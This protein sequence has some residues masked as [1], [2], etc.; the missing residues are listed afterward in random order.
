M[1]SSN[2]MWMNLN[3]K[4]CHLILK[5]RKCLFPYWAQISQ[6]WEISQAVYQLLQNTLEPSAPRRRSTKDNGLT[7]ELG[8]VYNFVKRLLSLKMSTKTKRD[9]YSTPP[10]TK[11]RSEAHIN[12]LTPKRK[13]PRNGRKPPSS[14]YI[15]DEEVVAM[16]LG[17]FKEGSREINEISLENS[18]QLVKKLIALRM[19]QRIRS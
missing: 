7:V 1:F 3:Q 2:L 17:G 11:R 14:S 5:R 10:R 6:R 18:L 13:K 4:C 9:S 16:Q 12:V 8:T 15:N 19:D